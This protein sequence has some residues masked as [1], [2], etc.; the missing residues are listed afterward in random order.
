MV[1]ILAGDHL[2]RMDYS[3]MAEFHREMDA[4]ITVAVH[5]VSREEAPRFGLLKRDGSGRILDFVEKPK[6][7]EVQARFEG[8]DDPHRPFQGSMGIYLFKTETLF[9]VLT[10]TEDHDFGGDVIPRAIDTNDVFGFEFD[11]YWEDIGTIRSFYEVNL[12][13]TR[14]DP[15]FS[16]HDPVHPIF[17]RPR[18]LPGP[19]VDGAV[20]HNTLLA[21]G[22]RIG[23]AEI[24]RSV[25]GLR[26][27]LRDGVFLKD[28]ILMGSDYYEPVAQASGG[29]PL[30]L[31]EGCHIEG[32]IIDKNVR[33]GAGVKI[34]PFPRGT[35]F[36]GPD[37]VVR[38]GIVVVPK[39][40][41]LPPGM[42]IAPD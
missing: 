17:T 10:G 37:W 23:K 42:V 8:R 5:P 6:D 24:H 11:G 22:C 39:N 15:P 31:C 18:F 16:L 33:L 34:L 2:Y 14:P 7:P 40:T 1:L 9:D 32:A 36:E 27:V 29:L 28:T 19:R 4:D 38:D 30:C 20:L 25:V 35:E 13:L 3:A 26:S 12:S 41:E 21:D